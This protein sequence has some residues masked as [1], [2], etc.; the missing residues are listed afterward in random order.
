MPPAEAEYFGVAYLL[1]QSGENL[2]S[3]E[4]VEEKDPDDDDCDE[5][6]GSSM[7]EGFIDSSA[8]LP[9]FEEQ[10]LMVSTDAPGDEDVVREKDT[11]SESDE[12]PEEEV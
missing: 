12:M 3:I 8:N 2:K 5:V 4:E 11:E 7:D 6:Q 10:D 9:Q 1:H